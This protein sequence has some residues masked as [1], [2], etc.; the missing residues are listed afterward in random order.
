[1]PETLTLRALNR[2]TLDRQL[3]LGRHPMPA[4]Q[5]IAHLGGM[6]AQAPLAPYTGLWSRL[7]DFRPEE[8]STLISERAVVRAHLMRSTVHLLTARDYLDFRP[9]FIQISSRVARTNF[10]RGLAGA[11]P[12]AIVA[13]A[14]EVLA[15]NGPQTRAELG[16]R[17]A[18]HWPDA[19]QNALA[20]VGGSA[21]STVQVP[22]RGIWGE[23]GQARFALAEDWLGG[24]IPDQPDPAAAERL[25]LR[26]IGAFG[27]MTVADLQLWSGLTRLREITERL[28]LRVFRGEEGAELLDL[29]DAPRPDPQTPASP[30]FL[31]EY[32]NLLLSHADRSRVIPHG[33]PVPLPPGN[34]STRGTVLIDGLWN[35]T[36]RVSGEI[37][38]IESFVPLTG[39]EADAIGAEGMRLLGFLGAAAPEIRFG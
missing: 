18:E 30:R 8:L 5:A 10:I 24:P 1:V 29:P 32:D 38:T 13:G 31:P 2:A 19:D 6:Q 36:W 25:V 7:E 20:Y 9:L 37:M 22:P 15:V 3:L 26:G 14:R 23:K 12:E 35:G 33:R 39:E 27:P 28:E 17:L 16:R 11:D 21:L 4:K 34:G